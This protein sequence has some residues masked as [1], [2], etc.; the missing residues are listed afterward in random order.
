MLATRTFLSCKV[1][2]LH[3]KSM[4]ENNSRK[5][6]LT[7]VYKPQKQ[8]WAAPLSFK[9]KQE[10]WVCWTVLVQW[11]SIPQI[12]RKADTSVL[13]QS[14]T[15]TCKLTLM[16]YFIMI[17]FEIMTQISLGLFCMQRPRSFCSSR[18]NLFQFQQSSKILFHLSFWVCCNICRFAILMFL[19]LN[20]SLCRL[21]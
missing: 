12:S 17:L 13:R 2:R 7:L 3:I 8:N 14:Y 5:T 20:Y 10:E 18:G 19:N 15:A 6:S 11:P 4:M 1:S 16:K 21:L 9:V